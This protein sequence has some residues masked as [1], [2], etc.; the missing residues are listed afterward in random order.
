[1]SSKEIPDLPAGT[2]PTGAE[3]MHMVQGG[4]SR[5][6]T[7]QDLATFIIALLVDSAPATLDTLNELAAAIGDDPNFAATIAGQLGTLTGDVD[8]LEAAVAAI[9]A[10]IAALGTAAEMDL[11]LT[12]NFTA[13]GEVR[14]HAD[15]AMTLAQVATSGTGTV[16]YEKSTAA[17]PAVF[18]ATAA[19][20][21]LEAGAWL[22]VIA[23]DVDTIF[24]VHL[25]RSA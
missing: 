25:K 1:M 19:P 5:K 16:S 21:T 24:A 8:A 20:V 17:A 13:D 12:P 18:A 22:R 11:P 4:N 15:V 2:A 23:A 3:W 7:T 14:F 10:A 6:L 9:E